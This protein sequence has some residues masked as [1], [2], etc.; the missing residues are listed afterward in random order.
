MRAGGDL[1]RALLDTRRAAAGGKLVLPYYCL[2]CYSGPAF[3]L[4]LIAPYQPLT[5]PL[6]RPHS[7]LTTPYCPLI[8]PYHPR[9]ATLLQAEDRVH[10]IGQTARRVEIE[11]WL[12]GGT[13]DELL[14]P[15]LQRKARVHAC[16]YVACHVRMCM[17]MSHVHVHVACA[18][19]CAYV[20]VR[21]HMHVMR[22]R[23]GAYGCRRAWLGMPLVA[24]AASPPPPASP[25]MLYALPEAPPPPEAPQQPGVPWSRASSA[26]A[27]RAQWAWSRLRLTT[28]GRRWLRW[29]A[30]WR[31]MPWTTRCLGV[32][33]RCHFHPIIPHAPSP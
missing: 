22:F 33:S 8:T 31:V 30:I 25:S 26:R 18:C 10:R 32:R 24:T 4:P 29:R 28:S 17:C 5:A 14:W 1:P 16:A 20:H 2:P 6:L 9:T 27:R 21:V 23:L 15:L 3:V 7:P 13:I 11:Y 12:G 19:A